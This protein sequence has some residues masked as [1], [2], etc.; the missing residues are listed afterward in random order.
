MLNNSTLLSIIANSIE[1]FG[2]KYILTGIVLEWDVC[3]SAWWVS[4]LWQP[5]TTRTFHK[6]PHINNPQQ[7]NSMTCQAL[8]MPEEWRRRNEMKWREEYVL[9]SAK[10]QQRDI[11]AL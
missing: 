6:L 2:N 7:M 9:L 10:C 5:T 1:Q 8:A 4:F 11:I 3:G